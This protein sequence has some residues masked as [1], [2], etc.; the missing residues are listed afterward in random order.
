MPRIPHKHIDGVEHKRCCRCKEWKLLSNFHKCKSSWD[1]LGKRCCDCNKL[2]NEIYSS[3]THV[4]IKKKQYYEKYMS[5][6]INREKVLARKRKYNSLDH[7]KLA[8]K[9]YAEAHIKERVVYNRAY[10]RKKYKENHTFRT[11]VLLRCRLKD[12]LKKKHTKQSNTTN[13]LL[14][15]NINSITVHLEKQFYE[16]MTWQNSGLNGWEVDHRIP[17]AAFDMENALHQK[18]C[19][20]Y[21]NLQPLWAKDNRQKSN[22]YKEEDKQVLIKEWIFYNI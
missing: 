6:P 21:R 9:K 4:K 22:K 8:K 2:C 7:V 3:Q 12:I 11:S 1:N 14:G 20:W 15:K 16:Y 17:I 5:N 18:I 19:Y 13:K 10:R